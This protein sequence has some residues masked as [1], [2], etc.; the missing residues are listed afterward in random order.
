MRSRVLDVAPGA[1]AEHAIAQGLVGTGD[2]LAEPPGAIDD[3]VEAAARTHGDRVGRMLRRFAGLPAGAFVWTRTADGAF[4]LG[5]ITGA[6]R[7]DD[8]PAAR[9]V[10][11][12]HVRPAAWL[13]EPFDDDDVP[14]GVAATF[15]RGGRNLQQTHGA[16]TERRT[17]DLWERFGPAAG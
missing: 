16:D 7:Y 8:S 15:A 13:D 3:A 5:R 2:A 1:G 6:W 9:A 17:A 10:G 12:H 14:P 4:R 11:I